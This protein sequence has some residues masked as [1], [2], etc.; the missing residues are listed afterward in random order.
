MLYIADN[1]A[2]DLDEDEGKI[3]DPTAVV[4]YA[5]PARA[6]SGGGGGCSAGV[7]AAALFVFPAL[8]LFGGVLRKRAR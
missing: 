8:W 4:K 2:Y 3:I 1:G 6:A 5:A 7:G